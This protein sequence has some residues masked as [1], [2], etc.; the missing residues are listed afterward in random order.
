MKNNQP[1]RSGR[2]SRSAVVF[3]EL[4][5]PIFLLRSAVPIALQA[6]APAN[7]NW[8]QQDAAVFEPEP[9]ASPSRRQGKPCQKSDSEHSS[10]PA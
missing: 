9:D 2:K 3:S 4:G 5:I 10:G 6:L 7:V 8:L 1:L